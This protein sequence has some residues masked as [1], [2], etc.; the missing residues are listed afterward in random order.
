M[1]V[2]ESSYRYALESLKYLIETCSECDG[3]Y[4]GEE[5]KL[6]IDNLYL[7]AGGHQHVQ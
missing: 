6:F 5:V 2:N 7:L 3:M 1:I 4:V